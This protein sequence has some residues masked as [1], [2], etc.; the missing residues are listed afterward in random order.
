ML[1]DMVHEQKG[2]IFASTHGR[3]SRL[4]HVA[5]VLWSRCTGDRSLET[6]HWVNRV[7]SVATVTAV[8]FR[9]AMYHITIIFIHFYDF[10]KTYTFTTAIKKII[11]N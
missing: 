11:V 6:V 1:S 9:S 8:C 10:T 3:P 4:F 2:E 5:L 7:F